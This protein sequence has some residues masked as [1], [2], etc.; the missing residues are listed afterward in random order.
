MMDY[1]NSEELL[2]QPDIVLS[3]N[4]KHTAK[5]Y[6]IYPLQEAVALGLVLALA[7]S[8][9]TYFI[10]F[11]AFNA[12]DDEIKEGLIRTARAVSTVVDGDSHKTFVDRSQETSAEYL[13]AIEPLK[14]ILE[15]DETIAFLYTIILKDDKIYFILD[16]T[17][18]DSLD[19]EGIQV[20]SHI[21]DEY[22]GASPEI[23]MLVA[24]REHKATVTNNPE[25]DR[26]GTFLSGFAPIF[27][28][29]NEFVAVVGVDIDVDDYLARLEPIEI[30]T[31]RAL[32]TALF[33]AVI[34]GALVWFMRNF[35]KVINKKRIDMMIDL[36]QSKLG[37]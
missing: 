12:L 6:R 26:W 32:V 27:D 37:E 11:H 1:E 15:I 30:A 18:P 23:E 29:R 4:K 33:L 16:P 19:D 9:T 10:H 36:N 2:D 13:Q 14:K 5:N 25:T 35:L 3:L 20:K 21:M 8:I 28:S 7:V 17:D 34:I 24:L 31:N 22:H